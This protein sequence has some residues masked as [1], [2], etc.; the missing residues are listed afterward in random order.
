[1]VI[2]VKIR[3]VSFGDWDQ[4]I[5]QCV[6]FISECGFRW[7]FFSWRIVYLNWYTMWSLHLLSCLVMNLADGRHYLVTWEKHTHCADFGGVL[8][9]SFLDSL[10]IVDFVWLP[11]M[12]ASCSQFLLARPGPRRVPGQCILLSTDD[13]PYSQRHS[14]IPTAGHPHRLRLHSRCACCR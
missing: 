11:L 12:W 5:Y 7:T 2:T 14:H 8:S 3:R 6:N 4:E 1:M 13:P 10:N 9:L